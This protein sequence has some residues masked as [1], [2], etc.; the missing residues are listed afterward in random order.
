M[1]ATSA[2]A[3]ALATAAAPPAAEVTFSL[4]E[5]SLAVPPS[6]PPEVQPVPPMLETPPALP[7]AL[8]SPPELEAELR[9]KARAIS[10]EFEEDY[11]RS[12]G[13]LL[14]RLR[15]DLEE[16]AASD[17]ERNRQQALESLQAIAQKIREQLEQESAARATSDAARAAQLEE[18]RQARDYVESLTRLLPQ[19]LDQR[20][21]EALAP[22]AEQWHQRLRN[23]HAAQHRDLS[24]QLQQ[25]CQAHADELAAQAR[26]R[27]FDDLD[28]HEREFLDRIAVRLE[29]VRASAD[30]T[31]EFTKRTSAEIARQSEQ[32]RVDLQTEFDSLFEQHRRDLATKLEG[33]HQQLSQAA[34][35]ALQN[36]GGRLWESLQHRLK[37]DFEARNQE[38]RDTLQ[39]AQA[40]T[41]QLREHTKELAARL[42]TG[43]Q[44]RLDQ[45]VDDATNRA[46]SR[47]EQLEAAA[48]EEDRRRLE[49]ERECADALR[50]RMQQVFAES[51]EAQRAALLAE[52]KRETEAI[53]AG[54]RLKF[55]GAMRQ[56]LESIGEILGPKP[57]Q[58]GTNVEPGAKES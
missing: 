41:R 16:Q 12:L 47:F 27:L 40:E 48:H 36:L 20:L 14:M 13:E 54:S 49:S 4:E 6:A 30:H 22:L 15:A 42:D 23:D 32:L 24:A 3:I 44:A 8:D 25:Q 50:V 52:F 33:R 38:L 46:Q 35:T 29:E 17:S 2:E 58:P 31:R 21:Q 28:R 26:Q 43:L 9:Q 56:T 7:L 55:Q 39:A 11:R 53:A 1:A 57:T 34:H 5:I 51:L 10:A 19:T 18:V 45:A 37:A